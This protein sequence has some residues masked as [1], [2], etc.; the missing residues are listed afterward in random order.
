MKIKSYIS[1]VILSASFI[2]ILPIQAM[3]LDDSEK[4]RA[5]AAAQPVKNHLVTHVYLDLSGLPPRSE[6]KLTLNDTLIT[7]SESGFFPLKTSAYPL[8]THATGYDSRPAFTHDCLKIVQIV[9]GGISGVFRSLDRKEASPNHIS[10]Y[11]HGN[12]FDQYKD[13]NSTYTIRFSSDIP[14]NGMDY[15]KANGTPGSYTP[16][17]EK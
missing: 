7:T 2:S 15:F 6:V 8:S 10:G 4:S 14:I 9:N 12:L 16:I 11:I 13:I 17:A 3:E 5:A 1:A